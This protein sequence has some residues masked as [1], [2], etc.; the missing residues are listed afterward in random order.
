M[1][2]SVKTNLLPPYQWYAHRDRHGRYDWE[3]IFHHPMLV[4]MCGDGPVVP[5]LLEI[6]PDER[7]WNRKEP[8][9]GWLEPDASSL[10]MV[11][12]S[13]Q[14]LSICFAYGID[15]AINNGDGK[16]VKLI[17]TQRDD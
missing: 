8:Y 7:S 9:W 1:V 17:V 3:N 16:P 14:M 10:S 13:Y 6:A 11:Q 15:A 12:N 5:V 2:K 4:K